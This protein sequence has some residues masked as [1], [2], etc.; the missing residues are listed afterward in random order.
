[1]AKDQNPK[2][3]DVELMA[4]SEPKLEWSTAKVHDGKL[5]V[6]LDA[7]PKSDWKASF[8]RVAKLIGADWD[9]VVIKKRKI[10]VKGAMEGREEKLRHFLESVVKQ[11]NADRRAT[12]AASNGDAQSADEGE[13]DAGEEDDPDSRMT[14]RFRAFSSDAG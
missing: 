8:E 13:G 5:T 12:E 14:E 3:Q 11:A 2:P 1:V 4:R 10:S 7:S 9:E 6:D